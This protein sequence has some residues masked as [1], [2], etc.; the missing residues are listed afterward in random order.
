MNKVVIS[1]LFLIVGI[2]STFVQVLIPSLKQQYN[3][4]YFQIGFFDA[5]FF[6]SYGLFSFI[7][8]IIAKRIKPTKMIN[9]GLI[10][11]IIAYLG[12]LI[13][14]ITSPSNFYYLLVSQFLLSIGIVAIFTCCEYIALFEK[15]IYSVKRLSKYES[16]HSIGAFLAPFLIS[17]LLTLSI[18][19]NSQNIVFIM[20]FIVM[21]AFAYFIK[22]TLKK[23]TEFKAPFYKDKSINILF[24]TKHFKSAIFSFISL[25]IYVGIEITVATYL[26]LLEKQTLQSSGL[27]LSLYWLLIFI[28]RLIGGKLLKNSKQVFTIV[29]VSLIGILLLI[30]GLLFSKLT[31]AMLVLCGLTNSVLFPVIFSLGFYFN[32]QKNI[33][34]SGFMLT[35]ISGGAFIPLIT[36]IIVDAT[37]IYSSLIVCAV[38]YGILVI[39]NLYLN[40]NK[41]A[42]ANYI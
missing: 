12:W 29:T 11:V 27:Y 38:C 40:S 4:S 6:I 39:I 41:S 15:N 13:C 5:A 32:K 24:L 36:G 30:V 18:F 2:S 3:L 25:M 22:I 28:G 42:K 34:L 16:I 21:I 35:A 14:Q 26:V 10:L 31:I 17:S 9:Y 33:E 1:G 7:F 20:F 8:A 23:S 37:N 19:V